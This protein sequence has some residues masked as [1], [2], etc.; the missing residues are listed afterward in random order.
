MLPSTTYCRTSKRGVCAN[1]VEAAT[2]DATMPDLNAR[3]KYARHDCMPIL[4]KGFA[5]S[6]LAYRQD[7]NPKDNRP[8][9]FAIFRCYM[10]YSPFLWLKCDTC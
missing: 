2:I 1:P 9:S 5:D 8:V 7:L 10:R 4:P 3:L 6:G